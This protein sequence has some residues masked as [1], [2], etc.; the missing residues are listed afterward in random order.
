M[1]YQDYLTERLLKHADYLRTRY[2]GTSDAPPEE[3]QRLVDYTL[4]LANFG[5]E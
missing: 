3:V 5:G 1:T 4:D 2:G